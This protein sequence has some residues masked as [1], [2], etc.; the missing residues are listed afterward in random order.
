[1][2]NQKLRKKILLASYQSNACHLG[3]SLSAIDIIKEIYKK[4]KKDD[5]F[6]FAK[7]SGVSALYCYLYP[8]KKATEYLKKY[9]LPAREAG[10]IH[11]LGSLG[12]GLPFAAGLALANK[13][14]NV[15]VLIGEGDVQ[16]GTFWESILFKRQHKLNNLK[17]ILD[18]NGLQALG[19]VKDILD[20]PYNFLKQNGVKV[21]KTTKGKGVKMLEEIGYRNH[22]LN[23]DENGF[24]KAIFQ[25]TSKKSKAR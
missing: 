17:I 15:Y 10:L 21:I 11:S 9:P 1:M 5:I 20:L 8:L 24:K 13:K 7:A 6:V 16:E 25:L 2:K 12:H 18:N 14:R 22:Y 4:K 3:G 23:L 19:K